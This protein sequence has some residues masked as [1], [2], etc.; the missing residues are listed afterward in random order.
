MRIPV[1][2]FLREK[3]TILG[4]ISLLT[5]FEVLE[6]CHRW[7]T[8]NPIFDLNIFFSEFDDFAINK[9]YALWQ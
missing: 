1:S 3:K 6:G 4:T 7:L 2:S 9:Q 5:L 8:C